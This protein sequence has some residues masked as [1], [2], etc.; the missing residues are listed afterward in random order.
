MD[1]LFNLES[2]QP[3]TPRHRALSNT[4]RHETC[5]DC[6]A[7]IIEALTDGRQHTLVDPVTIPLEAVHAANHLHVQVWR[8]KPSMFGQPTDLYWAHPADTKYYKHH[9]YFWLPTHKCGSPPWP[10]VRIEKPA[11]RFT[12][13]DPPF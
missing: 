1:S 7:H 4:P 3:L 5:P 13:S 12:P 8:S 11:P 2:K 10:G 9:E 6:G